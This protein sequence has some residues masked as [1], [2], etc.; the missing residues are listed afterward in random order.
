[1]TDL[2]TEA[3]LD[4]E[5]MAR[6]AGLAR[7]TAELDGV[8]PFL[9]AARSDAEFG[10]RMALAESR[11]EAIALQHGIAPGEV[12]D[13]ARRQ[14]ALYREALAEG[15]DPL[16][17][18]LQSTHSY[19]TGPEEADHHDVAFGGGLGY[20]EVPA[21]NLPGGPNPAVT[22]PRFPGP[23]PLIDAQAKRKNKKN[24]RHK[25]G[26]RRTAQG[27]DYLSETPPDTGTGPG[28]QDIGVEGPAGPPSIPAGMPGQAGSNTPIMN[29]QVTSSKDPVRRQVLAVAESIRATNPWL[30]EDQVLRV[31]RTTVARYFPKA[32]GTDWSPSIVSDAPPRQ[33]GDGGG[34][35]DSGGT[36]P[37]GHMLEWKGLK[38]M[39]PGG[40]GGAAGAAGEAGEVA[41]LA[42]L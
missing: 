33:T 28:S 26:S 20:S 7:V 39:M 4:H 25:T 11:L 40:G 16:D 15:Q 12:T 42:A 35:G 30:P 1:M 23:E 22:Q 41:E 21:G 6:E 17:E 14:Y 10:H 29:R 18:V 9:L 36:G 37:L 3:S 8:M 2:W 38:S 5:L 13:L 19:G 24:G 31:A 27:G 32:A 34:S